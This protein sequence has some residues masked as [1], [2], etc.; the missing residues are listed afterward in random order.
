MQNHIA[1]IRHRYLNIQEYIT[2]I[3]PK[4]WIK[5]LFIILPF[6]FGQQLHQLKNLEIYLVILAMCF[7]ASAV[8]ILN[9]W[10]DIEK[11]KIHPTKRSRP[12]ASNSIKLHT[13][14]I[15][16]FLLVI[17]ALSIGFYFNKTIGFLLL[18]YFVL[19]VC[20]S[21]KLKDFAI[22][23]ITIISIGFVIRIFIGGVAGNITISKWFVLMVY[24][25]SLV[26]ALGKRRDDLILQGKNE[27]DSLLFRKSLNGYNVEFINFSVSSLSV[28]AIV[29]YIMYT[30]SYDLINRVH[31]EYIYLTIFPVIMGFI[32]YFQVIYVNNN[33]GS[34]T[35][36]ILSDGQLQ[37]WVAL[38]IISY[39]ILTS[40]PF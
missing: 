4:H 7:M 8:Y 18:F 29:C 35:K 37:F 3:R 13:A 23:D 32:R 33:T 5:N 36:L 6:F 31:S 10:K 12:L 9:D 27:S 2:L 39:T 22:I 16:F 26:L 21:L 40:I 38:W 20:Y 34:P 24:L 25:L 28:I 14:F 15:L 19:N 11:D 1:L 17:T 30:F